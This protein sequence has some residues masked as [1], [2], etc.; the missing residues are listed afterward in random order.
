MFPPGL[1]IG[2]VQDIDLDERQ[3]FL[4]A[5]LNSALA[6]VPLRDVGILVKRNE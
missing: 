1:T 5:K 2:W 3:L 6:S 4:Q